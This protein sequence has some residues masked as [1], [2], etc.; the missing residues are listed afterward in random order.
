MIIAYATDADLSS[1]SKYNFILG[2]CCCN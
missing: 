1:L 2:C